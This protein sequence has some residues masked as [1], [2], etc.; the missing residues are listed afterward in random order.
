MQAVELTQAE[1]AGFFANVVVPYVG[2]SAIKRW[3][4]GLLGASDILRDPSGA[5]TSRPVFELR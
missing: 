4:L 5:A 1:V 2:N 3:L